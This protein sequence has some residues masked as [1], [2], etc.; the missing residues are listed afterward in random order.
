MAA[1]P[2]ENFRL[3]DEADICQSRIVVLLEVGNDHLA[4]IADEKA[5]RDRSEPATIDLRQQMMRHLLLVENA[6][7][8]GNVSRQAHDYFSPIG[9]TARDHP[10]GSPTS[11]SSRW[12]YCAVLTTSRCGRAHRSP[13][14]E[15][16]TFF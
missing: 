12:R 15:L 3:L 4:R 7:S 10:G 5:V 2:I 16:L 8:P 14:A 11:A 6:F 1:D 9:L 13:C